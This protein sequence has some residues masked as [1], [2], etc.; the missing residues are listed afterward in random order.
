M[1]KKEIMSEKLGEGRIKSMTE[2]KIN[3]GKKCE[4]GKRGKKW[5]RR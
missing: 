5:I 3:E 2:K 4:N 1:E